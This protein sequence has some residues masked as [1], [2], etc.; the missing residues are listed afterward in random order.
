LPGVC[1]YNYLSHLDNGVTRPGS[2]LKLS[3]PL[4]VCTVTE[5]SYNYVGE[6]KDLNQITY[7]NNNCVCNAYLALTLRHQANTP[8]LNL[9]FIKRFERELFKFLDDNKNLVIDN[10]LT[11]E[12]VVNGYRGRWFMRYN[13][14]RLELQKRPLSRKDFY[15]DCFVKADKEE[16]IKKA[17]RLIQYMKATGALEM[18]RFTHAVEGEIYK[19]KDR[20][21]TKIFGKG[22][23]LHELAD[24]FRK[25][26]S[27]FHDPVYILLDATNFD[28]HV[29]MELTAAMTEF[30][31]RLV[32]N[33]KHAQ[34][35]RWLWN[36]VLVSFG[37]SKLGLR[38]KTRGTVFSGRMDT[39]LFDGMTT[40][41]MLSAYMRDSGITKY[42]LSVNGD[43]SV[44]IIERADFGNLLKMDY[45]LN[46][47]FVMKFEWTDDFSKM[48]YCQTRPVET[49]YGWM[50]ARGPERMLRRSGWSVKF[51]GKKFYKSYI[52][53]LGLGEM[54]I[55]YACPIGYKLGKLMYNAGGGAKLLPVD[56]KSYIS[57]T[58]QKYWQVIDNPTI[59]M[60]TRLSYQAAWGITPEEQIRI[61]KELVINL[62][63]Y[64]T[65][66]QQWEYER[67]L[68]NRLI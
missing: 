44:T 62:T 10:L 55:N 3:A 22:C 60:P 64:V 53:S 21:G 46:F 12:E 52:K 45:F 67:I 1:L 54:A 2:W 18:G 36:H 38:Y 63:P 27:F 23:N 61:E 4:G 50:M 14:A 58:K 15:N 28:A 9:M 30:Y 47:G 33:P 11:R 59:S 25:K 16:C 8:P 56:R 5:K 31:V 66:Q 42:S 40:F 41:A 37:F 35:V 68:S 34:L 7:T 39:G 19:T 48:D 20:F 29:S 6:I 65:K 32:K 26:I 43:D 13:K 49:Y 24:D 51:F 17:A 57:Y